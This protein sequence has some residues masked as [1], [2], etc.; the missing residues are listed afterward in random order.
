[1]CLV[2][3]PA[4]W[5]VSSAARSH[6]DKVPPVTV[7]S[8]DSGDAFQTSVYGTSTAPAATGAT[9]EMGR[10]LTRQTHGKTRPPQAIPKKQG[11]AAAVSAKRAA[12]GRKAS[13]PMLGKRQ[14]LHR[15]HF[16]S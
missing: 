16:S 1:M 10:R 4:G 15:Q 2:V 14:L 6:R 7:G 5:Q 8:R 11:T 3:H 9:T 13:G 12:D